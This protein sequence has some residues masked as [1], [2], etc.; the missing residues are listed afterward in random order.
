MC[1]SCVAI[2]ATSRRALMKRHA[3]LVRTRQARVDVIGGGRGDGVHGADLKELVSV[4]IPK[5]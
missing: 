2:D 1:F 3:V 5:L 4:P